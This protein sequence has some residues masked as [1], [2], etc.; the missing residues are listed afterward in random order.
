[1]LFA[2]ALVVDVVVIVTVAAVP[3]R[4]EEGLMVAVTPVGA[5][6]VRVTLFFA[7]PLSV[8]VSVNVVDLL[9][10]TVPLAA[11]AVIAKST[12]EPVP[13][14]PPPQLCTSTAPSTDPN[15]VAML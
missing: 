5:D 9:A 15:P 10:N 6:A 7:V 4:I 1:M 2:P 13:P 11:D 12:L 14:D 3:G 8:T